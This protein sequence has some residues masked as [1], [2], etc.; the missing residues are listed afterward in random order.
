MQLQLP[1]DTYMHTM[2]LIN[3][4]LMA[5]FTQSKSMCTPVIERNV[6]CGLE[7]KLYLKMVLL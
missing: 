2:M 7:Q 5:H 4:S 6:E 1:D 3:V